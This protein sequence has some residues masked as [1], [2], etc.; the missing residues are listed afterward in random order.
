[1]ANARGIAGLAEPVIHLIDH[2]E[3]AQ[4]IEELAWI[5]NELITLADDADGMLANPCAAAPQRLAAAAA[6]K[7]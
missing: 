2:T 3:R 6:G 7:S 1:L 5:A 4:S